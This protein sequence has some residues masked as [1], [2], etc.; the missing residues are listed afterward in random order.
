MNQKYNTKSFVEK[1]ES[2]HGKTYD[3]SLVKYTNSKAKVN[4]I[5]RTHGSFSQ[6]ADMHISKNKPQGCPKCNKSF[7][8]TTE[9]FI[10]KAIEIHGNK[11]NYSKSVYLSARKKIIITCPIHGDFL[12]L[13]KVHINNRG[14]CPFCG[15]ES[16][17]KAKDMLIEE[18]FIK[19]GYN[20]TFK[21]DNYI[22]EN[23][24]ILIQC[25]KHGECI[26]KASV[27]ICSIFACKQCALE[28]RSKLLTHSTEK[29]IY[30]S[31]KIHNNFYD[32]SLS[33]YSGNKTKL[34][35]ICPEHGEFNQSPSD[36][37]QGK[38]CPKCYYSKGELKVEN[39]LKNK[40]INFISQKRF[41]DCVYK[42]PLPFDFYL[43]D[44]NTCIEFDGAQHFIPVK[45][46]GGIEGLLQSKERDKI[47]NEYCK[48]NKINL[49]RIKY[50][51]NIE[52]IL[53][54]F[55]KII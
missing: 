32:Y 30:M 49:I 23:S 10:E 6:R 55:F 38:G 14:G 44:Y 2:I 25:P 3:Y 35:I 4:I 20:Y 34:K 9:S 43:K 42:Q 29:F 13:G 54:S 48:K 46:W 18:L 31:N 8:L 5:C 15:I 40:K 22:G 1:S 37:K 17:I 21:I 12:Q 52:D 16:K 26:K 53:E 39:F 41:I 45:F 50:T 28:N 24:K 36:H 33:I 7:K 27:L 51:D 11:Y 19:F 47:K